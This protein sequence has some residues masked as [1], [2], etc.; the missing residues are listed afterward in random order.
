MNNPYLIEPPFSV[1]FSGGESSA[2]MLRNILDAYGGQL[3]SNSKVL[4]A[5]TGLE[6]EKTYKFV[7]E[8]STRWSVDV[9]WIEYDPENRFKVVTPDSARTNGEPFDELIEKKGF[10]PTPVSRMCTTNLKMR[11]MIHYLKSLG[12]DD[13][14][15]AIGLRADEP[16]RALGI[17]GD[18]ASE[19]PVCPMYHAGHTLEDVEEYWS[20]QAFRLDIPRWMGNCCG[21]FLKSRGRLEMVGD[22][23]PGQLEWWSK[24][25][26]R[27]GKT[28][29]I[30][31]P[32]YSQLLH[33][34]TI[35]GR[36]FEDDGSTIPC[37]CTD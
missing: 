20:N 36:L 21:C 34:I 27:T 28:F 22:A 17:K 3:P 12:W 31:R 9:T 11:A 6:H 24:T 1:S 37:R 13:W 35:Q 29:R 5:N 8:V 25:E 23:E 32:N 18:Y 14:D 10:L 15:S 26:Q 33:Q 30:D 4:F 19:H 16:K 7:N 2:F